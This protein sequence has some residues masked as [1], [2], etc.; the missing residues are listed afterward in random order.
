MA[1]RDAMLAEDG[2]RRVRVVSMPSW[3]LFADQPQTYRDEVLPPE[4]SAR[5]AVE[6]QAV[7]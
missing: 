5:L 6:A 3:E 4:V 7:D 2:H 1:A